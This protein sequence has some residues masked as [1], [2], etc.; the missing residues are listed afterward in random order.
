M[1]LFKQEIEL[2]LPPP[3]LWSKNFFNKNCLISTQEFKII[4]KTGDG[5]I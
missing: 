3:V 1:D 4:F 2:F 5:I